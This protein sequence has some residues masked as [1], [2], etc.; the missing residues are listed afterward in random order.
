MYSLGDKREVCWDKHIVD[1]MENAS[2]LMHKP[3]RK[4]VV[5]DCNEKW[6]ELRAGYLS[7]H[8]I[9][10]KYRLYYR[11]SGSRDKKKECFCVAESLDGKSFYRLP[12]EKYEYDGAR[13]N[14]IFFMEDRFVDNFSIHIDTNPDCPP[15]EKYKALSLKIEK[16]DG[17]YHLDLLYYK[18]ADGFDFQYVCMLDVPGIFDTHNVVIWDE[19]E[20]EYKMYIRDFHDYDGS[21][22]NY[23]PR[24]DIMEP[25]YRDVR[26]TRSKDFVH[27]SAPEMIRYTDNDLHIQMYTNQIMK[28]PRADIYLGMPVRYVN[29]VKDK[30]N[31]KY[32]PDW[33]GLRTKYIESGDRHGTVAT[34]CVLMTSRDGSTFERF[35]EAFFAPGLEKT[36]NWQYGEGYF[37]HGIVETVCDENDELTEYSFY[38]SEGRWGELS[39]IVRYTVRLDGFFS[40]HANYYGGTVMTKPL[41]FEGDSMEMNFAT[42]SLGHVKITVCDEE[43]NAIEGYESGKLFGNSLCR[44]ID[45]EKPLSAL[46]GKTVRI[47]FELKDADLYSF[48]FN[49]SENATDV[50]KVTKSAESAPKSAEMKDEEL[51]SFKF[52]V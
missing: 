10:D 2:V 32:L 41:T 26:L 31:F 13:K 14:N 40:W 34:D 5:L 18:S 3:V 25:C 52:T 39:K 1:S 49:R 44:P 6:E 38:D 30:E 23:Y 12:L 37:S 21:R 45:F 9:G 19:K 4:N 46:S 33:Y 20:K 36:R 22:S 43:G 24:D 48:K 17:K 11:T 8:K 15:D 50:R 27:W 29:R 7:I 16:I 35:P 47:R 42:S 51:R 28:Y